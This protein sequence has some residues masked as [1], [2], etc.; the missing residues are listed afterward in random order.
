MEVSHSEQGRKFN[1]HN[2]FWVLW[3]IELIVMLVCLMDELQ[4]TYQS[5]APY[6]YLGF[7]IL[8]LAWMAKKV[9]SWPRLALVLV[10]VPGLL[11]GIMFLMFLL[12]L[13]VNFFAGPIRWN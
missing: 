8:F 1:I 2:V 13:A 3:T 11:L 5:P 6:I 9:L 12:I 7:L 4:L 10:S